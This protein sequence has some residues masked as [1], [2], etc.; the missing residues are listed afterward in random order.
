MSFVVRAAATGEGTPLP[1]GLEGYPPDADGVP[2]FY[3]KMKIARAGA[4][5]HRGTGEPVTIDHG[6]MDAWVKNTRALH[7]AGVRPFLP[8]QHRAEFNAAD[9]HGYVLD[10]AR[11][12]DDLYATVAL[13]GDDARRIAASNG[14]SVYVV[15]NARDA[16]GNVVEGE[17]I[18]HVALVPNPAL[19]D[20]GPTVKIAASA[21]GSPAEVP[22]IEPAAAKRSNPM[23]PET[24]QKLRTKFNLAA[25]VPDEQVAEKAAELALQDPPAPVEDKTAE[26]ARL[27]AA[28][29]A[30][31]ADVLRL[32]ASAPKN[33]DAITL[34]MY[35]DNIAAK[36]EAAI[37]SGA[38]SAAEAAHFDTLIADANGQP[39]PLALS[40]S[41]GGRPLAF[42]LWDAIGRLGANAIRTGNAVAR[43]NGEGTLALSAEKKADPA[44]IKNPTE[45]AK[46]EWQQATDED[47]AEFVSEKHFIAFREA[48]LTGAHVQA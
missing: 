27:S 15:S 14:R 36:R 3:R 48:V 12:G 46:A 6:R 32:S 20:L 41:T 38:I 13:Y 18:G 5:T 16:R 23:K 8:G 25:D 30:L 28:N 19:P 10:V 21:G 34:A 33:P 45:R 44:A 24:L 1:M 37:K 22:I 35:S 31:Q 17:S 4:W 29:A 42:A 2:I 26:V 7:L 40:A 39:T 43:T 47:R 9:N 11:D